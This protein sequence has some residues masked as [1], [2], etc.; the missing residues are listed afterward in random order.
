MNLLLIL[1]PLGYLWFCLINNLRLQWST[2]PQYAYG[3]VVP[4]LCLGLL[5]RRWPALPKEVSSSV[6]SSPVV[7]WSRGPVVL[8]L[9]LLALLFLPT[10]LAEAAMPEWR[11]IQWVLALQVVGLTLGAIYLGKGPGG[12]RQLAYPICFFLVAVPW[13]SFIDQ[14]VIQALTRADA[15]LVTELMGWLGEPAIRHGNVIEVSTGV[16]GIDEACSG[17]RSFQSSLMISLFFGEFYRLTTLRR[18]LLVPVGFL[19]AFAFNVC[20]TSLLTWVAAKKGIAA[21]SQYHDPAGIAI[22]LACSAVMWALALLLLKTQKSLL[23][24]PSSHLPPPPSPLPTAAVSGRWSVVSSPSST[25][26]RF[27]LAL[28]L[29]LVV[30]EAGVFL[31]YRSRESHFT[32]APNWSLVFPRDNPAFKDLPIS[33][34][35]KAQL[36]FDEAR[37][38]EWQAPDGTRWQG[39]YFAWAPGRVAAYLAKR[40]TPEICLTSSGRKLR[41]GPVLVPLRIHGVDLPM[42]Q[43]V[44]ETDRGLLHVFHAR[45]EPGTTIAD[46]VAREPG[47]YSYLR[48]IWAGRGNRGQKVVEFIGTGFQDARQAKEALVRQ[49]ETLIKVESPEPSTAK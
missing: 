30:C 22:L 48:S 23:P 37:E 38:A 2:D 35:E 41:S 25:L 42:R 36:R 9:S 7:P 28:I 26:P 18:L 6:V 10:R 19:M 34:I 13:P 17:I 3:W 24:T 11:L 27:G 44:F 4:L 12:L 15:T 33:E 31:W 46:Y 39:Y 14:A 29:W 49:L 1:L 16:V 20:R 5:L 45:W 43:Y 8:L 21:I 47:R 40:H 32:P